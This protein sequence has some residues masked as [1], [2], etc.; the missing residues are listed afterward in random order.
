MYKNILYKECEEALD[1]SNEW[2]KE[3]LNEIENNILDLDV[4][5]EG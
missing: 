5:I 1:S 3:K 4:E 2:A